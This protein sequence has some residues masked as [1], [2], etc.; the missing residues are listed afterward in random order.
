MVSEIIFLIF[1]AATFLFLGITCLAK[2]T[3]SE[4]S[5]QVDIEMQCNEVEELKLKWEQ[6]KR[7]G[8][9]FEGWDFEATYKSFI[10]KTLFIQNFKN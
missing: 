9:T 3:K 7:R 6:P 10:F 8:V 1:I 5:A 2:E 4:K